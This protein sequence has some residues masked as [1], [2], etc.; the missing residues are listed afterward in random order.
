MNACYFSST[1]TVLAMLLLLL[2]LIHSTEKIL[3]NMPINL[4]SICSMFQCEIPSRVQMHHEHNQK[5]FPNCMNHLRAIKSSIYINLPES[6]SE[7][8]SVSRRAFQRMFR[9]GL[10]AAQP[11]D[12]A[13]TIIDP[14]FI[15]I[16]PRL[17]IRSIII[18]LDLTISLEICFLL[19]FR[20]GPKLK[21][22]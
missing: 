19:A 21:M 1:L 4:A 5:N 3:S 13:G 20:L 2:L 6:S 14:Y 11:V 16:K 17:N 22:R 9:I 15:H 10:A 7:I 18:V 12:F 8:V